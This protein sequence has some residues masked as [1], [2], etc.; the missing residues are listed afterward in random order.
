MEQTATTGIS[1]ETLPF[2][3]DG[4]EMGALIRACDWSATPVGDPSAWP[5]SLRTIVWT[6]L[7]SKFPM[8]LY[9]SS[10][11]IQFYNDAFRPSLRKRRCRQPS[12]CCPN[13]FSLAHAMD[14]NGFLKGARRIQAIKPECGWAA[15][16]MEQ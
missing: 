2:L 10:E 11:L 3:Q 13:V 5:I 6:L 14:G 8:L 1:Q 15:S 16:N 4:G 9:W 7:N 12:M